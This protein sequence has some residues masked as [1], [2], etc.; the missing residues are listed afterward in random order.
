MKLLPC[1]LSAIGLFSLVA[2][3]ENDTNTANT[4]PV[5]PSNFALIGDMPYG[6]SPL[7]TAQFNANPAFIAKINADTSLAAVLH[8]GDIHSGKEYCTEAYNRSVYAQWLSFIAP[9]VYTPGDNEWADCHK[10]KEGGGTYDPSTQMINYIVDTNGKK[11]SYQGGQ[12]VDNLQLVRSIFFAKPTTTINQKLSL[13]TQAVDFDPAYPTDKEYAE[14]VWFEASKVLVATLNIPGGSN[15]DTDPWYGAPAMDTT[16]LTE[17]KNR[18]AANLRWL[19]TIFAKATANKDVAV[20]LQTQADMWDNDGKT[21]AHLSEYKQFIDRIASN[22]KVFGKPVLLINGDSHAY[23]SDNP[24]VAK[25]ACMIEK[26][27]PNNS[28]VESCSVS[29]LIPAANNP[30]DAYDTQPHGY[31]VPNFHRL[32]VHGS[33][34]PIEYVKL[35]IDPSLN[36]ANG[37]DAF[38]PFSWKRIAP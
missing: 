20:L 27:A 1:F 22:A 29:P 38:G 2:C 31:N 28:Q 35:T 34:T 17:V 18:S 11:V 14:N 19:D 6:S 8:V 16:Q 26:A 32:V 13:H 23:R 4:T 33:V 3:G 7:D 12:P 37:N 9:V 24:L 10:I 36:V 21:S 5:L 30:V 15:N 25:A